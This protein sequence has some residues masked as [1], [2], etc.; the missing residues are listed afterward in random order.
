MRKKAPSHHSVRD[1]STTINSTTRIDARVKL[2]MSCWNCRGLSSRLPYI[3]SLFEDGTRI[4]VLSEHWLWP[5]E[6]HKLNE[7]NQMYEA[8]GKSDSRLTEEKD[9]GRGCGGIGLL[10]HKNIAATPI[11][12]ISSDWICG[13]RFTVDDGDNSLMSVIGVYLPCLDQGVDCYREHLQELERLI[14]ESRLLGPVTLLGDFNA[15]LGGLES[16]QNVQGLLL[17][18]IME[19]CELSAIYQGVLASG[20]KHTFCSGNVRTTVDYILM[21]VEAASMVTSCVTHFMDDLNTSD[22][23]P[24]TASISYDACPGSQDSNP[25]S[26]KKI[27]WIGAEKN[28]DLVLFSD[29][30]RNKLEPLHVYSRV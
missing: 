1:K 22:H 30:I 10:W 20:P 4:L 5:Y 7:I 26:F 11:S 19:R 24:L 6:L 8:V 21:D 27:D 12:G 29:E 9:G 17:Q 28:G 25:P 15:H 18:E 2:K 3:N 14:S 13:V 16:Q 23:L